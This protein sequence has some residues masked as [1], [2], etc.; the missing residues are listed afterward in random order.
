MQVAPF[1]SNACSSTQSC[2][3]VLCVCVCASIAF[4]PFPCSHR[5][6]LKCPYIVCVCVCVRV[7]ARVR[8]HLSSLVRVYLCSC[9][10]Q[11]S[12]RG[13]KTNDV[14]DE[15]GSGDAVLEIVGYIPF[16]RE[17]ARA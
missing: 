3:C 7:N 5:R 12:S 11:R 10:Y 4:I 9:G 2:V 8:V 13:H 14:H 17:A 1:V 6:C 15:L 16:I